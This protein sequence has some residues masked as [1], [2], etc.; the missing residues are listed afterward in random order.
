[1]S[2][3]LLSPEFA[4][5][6]MGDTEVYANGEGYERTMILVG[7]DQNQPNRLAQV[8]MRID[9]IP[10]DSFA[11]ASVWSAHG[12]QEVLRPSS[13]TFWHGMPGYTRW[14]QDNADKKTEVLA[15]GLAQ[16]LG[17]IAENS[18]L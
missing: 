10:G 18:N 13:V 15:F 14:S 17:D 11:I 1:M 2:S 16:M 3:D 4:Y 12:W 7:W 8:R 5:K 9:R 6:I